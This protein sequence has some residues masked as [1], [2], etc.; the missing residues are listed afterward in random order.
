MF[1]TDLMGL[2]IKIK[3]LLVS[4]LLGFFAGTKW[5]GKYLA[6]GTIVVKQ[7]GEQEAYH[8]TDL[9]TLENYLYQNI[10]FDTPSTTRH[11]Y[12]SLFVEKDELYFKLNLQLRF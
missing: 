9:S 12:G 6:Q 5:N 8:I 2:K 3:K 10:R 11:R 4:I 7:D 1:S